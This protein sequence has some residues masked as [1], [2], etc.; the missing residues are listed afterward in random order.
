MPRF[1]TVI[2]F[3]FAFNTASAQS[4]EVGG[5]VGGAGYMGDLN[6]NNPLKISGAAG[7]VIVKY[8]FGP[9]LSAKA[10]YTYGHITGAD[11][12]SGNQQFRDRNL[13]FSTGLSELSLV[14]ELNF[15]SYVPSISKNI[16][17]PFIYAGVGL[18]SYSPKATFNRQ[19]YDLREYTT[20]G[21][22]A[23]YGTSALSI[24]FGVGIKYNI[25]GRL[26]LIADLGY[27]VART[28]FLD[29]VS[30]VYANKATLPGAISVALSDR[31]GER[32]GNYIGS[33][34]S[35]RGDLRARDTYLFVGFSLTYT[36][37]NSKC[38]F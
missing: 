10:A 23:P 8:N 18:V 19:V 13:S 38:Y 37:I 27:R 1:L 7:G 2:C 21:Q 9:Y 4:W 12:L 31:S 15:M 28:D 17:T 36:F 29:D 6:P 34:G 14:G 11:S 25:S 22:S 24:P 33:A 32:T 30:G 35:Q 20:E 16:Y 5:F 3:L 26:N